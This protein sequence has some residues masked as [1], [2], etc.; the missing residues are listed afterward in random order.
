MTYSNPSEQE[1]NKH[2][3]YKNGSFIRPANC[4]QFYW[5]EIWLRHGTNEY[6]GLHDILNRTKKKWVPED[7]DANL[8]LVGIF[9]SCLCWQTVVTF[10][11]ASI[12][13][14]FSC[15]VLH[16]KCYFEIMY[17]YKTNFCI[18]YVLFEFYSITSPFLSHI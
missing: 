1:H 9:T 16:R 10:I 13:R 3:R 7:N 15:I 8:V 6:I 5:V 17:G 12:E 11:R 2:I 14:N 18:L 4:A